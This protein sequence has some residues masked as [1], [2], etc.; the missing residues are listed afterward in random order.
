MT[1]FNLSDNPLKISCLGK[2][3]TQQTVADQGHHPRYIEIV[4]YDVIKTSLHPF[5]STTSGGRVVANEPQLVP[6]RAY[7]Q[8]IE[9]GWYK[10]GL[11]SNTRNFHS[12]Q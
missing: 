9:I 7:Q 10:D 5:I 11:V 1:Q 2:F 12:C 4:K 6:P 3:L 8:V